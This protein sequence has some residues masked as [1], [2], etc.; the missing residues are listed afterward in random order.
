MSSEASTQASGNGVGKTLR[1]LLDTLGE[2][3]CPGALSDHRHNE[4]PQHRDSVT[5]LDAGEEHD[6]AVIAMA[7]LMAKIWPSTPAHARPGQLPPMVT[8]FGIGIQLAQALDHAH[9]HQVGHRN[10]TPGNIMLDAVN[11]TGFGIA[12][13]T[14]ANRTQTGTMPGNPG[15]TSPE[16]SAGRRLTGRSDVY[17]LGVAQYH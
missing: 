13:V 6:H 14:G 2:S 8:V 1:A 16:R 9:R 10:I 5:V 12:R 17:S 4:R 7:F 15:F 11:V 3:L